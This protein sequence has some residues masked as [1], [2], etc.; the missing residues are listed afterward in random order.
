VRG[1]QDI[2]GKD[3]HTEQIGA[4]KSTRLAARGRGGRDSGREKAL[5]HLSGKAGARGWAG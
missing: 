3:A 1:P 5:T 2:E 4:D